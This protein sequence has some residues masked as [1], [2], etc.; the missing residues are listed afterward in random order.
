M[1]TFIQGVTLKYVHLNTLN[2]I[3]THLMTAKHT[4]RH[5]NTMT[6]KYT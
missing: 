5:L 4:Y 6:S 1:L 2:D 3:E